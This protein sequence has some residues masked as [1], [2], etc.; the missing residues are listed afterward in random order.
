MNLVHLYVTCTLIW[1]S[2][3]NFKKPRKFKFNFS[4]SIVTQRL[5]NAKKK[6]QKMLWMGEAQKSWSLYKVWK[7]ILR[8]CPK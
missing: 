7:I 3:M 6:H 1:Q 5:C 8:T 4:G 2:S